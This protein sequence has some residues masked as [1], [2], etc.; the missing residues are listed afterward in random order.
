MIQSFQDPANVSHLVPSQE[1]DTFF[2][3]NHRLKSE[4]TSRG[5]YHGPVAMATGRRHWSE[6]YMSVGMNEGN[7]Y[8]V[9]SSPQML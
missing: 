1:T 5:E 6:K 8:N 3:S 9:A 2:L 7:I 4:K